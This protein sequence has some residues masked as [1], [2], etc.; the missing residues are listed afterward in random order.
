MERRSGWEQE[1]K[2]SLAALLGSGSSPEF[3]QFDLQRE[4]IVYWISSFPN[5]VASTT[6]NRAGQQAWYIAFLF[7]IHSEQPHKTPRSG[8]QA[9]P[10][11]SFKHSSSSL[12]F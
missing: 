3:C 8:S 12:S 6:E 2:S 5:G 7:H 11:S 4:N 9:Q 1:I 10:A